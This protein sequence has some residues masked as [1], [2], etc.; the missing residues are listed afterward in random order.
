MNDAARCCASVLLHARREGWTLEPLTATRS[1]TMSQAYS[2]QRAMTALRISSGQRIVGWKLGYTS[3]AMRQQMGVDEPNFGPLLDRMLLADGATL[4]SCT[5]QPRVEPEIGVRLGRALAGQ[6]TRAEVEAALEDSFACLEVVDSVY[7]DY[8]F[9]IEDN[10]ADGS[11]AAFVVV[12][13]SLAPCGRLEEVPVVLERNGQVVG[14]AVGA[15]ASGHPLDGVVWLVAQLAAQGQALEAG[16]LVIT[17]GLT[18]AVPL[19]PGD[20]V[21]ATFG[22]RITVEVRRRYRRDRRGFP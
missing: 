3:Q 10:T 6:V 5:T 17:G 15:A 12:G 21:R 1:L 18:A 8:R 2:V 13:E 19:A 14:R 11:S 16:H 22:D 4:G 20:V 7:T 9:S